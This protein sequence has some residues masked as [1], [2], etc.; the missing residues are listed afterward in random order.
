MKEKIVNYITKDFSDRF[1]IRQ[2]SGSYLPGLILYEKIYNEIIFDMF[3]LEP[4]EEVLDKL[5]D[6][7]K[8]LTDK[9]I[10]HYIILPENKLS[11]AKKYIVLVSEDIKIA[12]YS[13]NRKNFIKFY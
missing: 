5:V 11:E 6:W 13:K 7:K 12:T 10:N 4:N 8:A 1:N 3:I 9:S 2:V